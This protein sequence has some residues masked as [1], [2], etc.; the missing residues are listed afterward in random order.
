[1]AWVG[2]VVSLVI[3]GVVIWAAYAY[4][5]EIMDAWPPSQRL[6]AALGLGPGS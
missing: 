1:M 3:W 5:S 6:Y 4:R 2:W